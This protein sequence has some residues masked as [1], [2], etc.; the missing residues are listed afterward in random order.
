M[1]VTVAIK[2]P[3]L[4]PG[5][6]LPAPPQPSQELKKILP[7]KNFKIQATWMFL[8]FFS[9]IFLSIIDLILTKQLEFD[10]FV[11]YSITVTR[12]NIF[13]FLQL[14]SH[15]DR[16]QRSNYEVPPVSELTHPVRGESGEVQVQIKNL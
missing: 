8:Y 14:Y 7:Q 2:R 11:C 4:P 12:K 16:F 6:F 13:F 5:T 15:F 1:R 3:A 10:A 9:K